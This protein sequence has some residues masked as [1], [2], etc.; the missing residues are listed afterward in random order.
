M[1]QLGAESASQRLLD[2]LGKGTRVE[3]TRAILVNLTRA[4]IRTYVYLLFGCPTESSDEAR[5]TL[6]WAASNA[7]AITFLNLALMNLPKGSALERDARHYGV[8][9][10]EPVRGG[11]DL[12]LYWAYEGEG[13]GGASGD[14]REMR[15]VLAEARAH[16]V[17]SRI[18][19]RTPPGFTS[20]HAAWAPL[21]DWPARD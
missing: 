16:P 11:N 18:L 8:T 10:L 21:D 15:R 2:L 12:S 14:R 7:G 4:G 1:L 3:E 9:A 5:A 13:A 20:N 19:A 17:L 6:T